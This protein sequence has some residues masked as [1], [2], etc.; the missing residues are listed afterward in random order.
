[1]V[2][3]K[4]ATVLAT[5]KEQKT[6]L[7]VHR[8]VARYVVFACGAVLLVFGIQ[9]LLA[10]AI[11]TAAWTLAMGVVIL[12]VASGIGAARYGDR[13]WYKILTSWYFWPWTN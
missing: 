12:T 13:L 8:V 2:E 6:A 9:S 1:M 10:R 4:A 5:P 11:W 3:R 7:P